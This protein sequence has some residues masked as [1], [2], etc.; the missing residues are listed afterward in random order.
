MVR[1]VEATDSSDQ[2]VREHAALRRVAT[3][4]AGQ[5][6]P[7]ELFAA[8]TE[9]AGRVLGAQTTNLMRVANPRLAVIVA[10]WSEGAAHVAVGSTGVLDGRGLVGKIVSTGRPSRVDDFDEVGGAVAASM[11]R[12]GLR[13][14][15][16]GPVVVDGRIWGAL[17]AC[18]A[19]AEPL[20]AGTED[21]VAA[22]AQLVALAIENAETREELAASRARLVAAADEA[23]RRIERD[24][25]DGAQQRLVATALSLSLLQRQLDKTSSGPS[26]LLVSA[27]E[28][29]DRG[30]CELREL[31]RGLHPA[32]LTDRGLEPAVRSLVG[33]VSV[34]TELRVAVPARLDP[35]IE[36]A[37]YFFV[38][39]ALTNVGKYANANSVSVELEVTGEALVATVTDDGIGG[40]DLAK[41]SGLRGLADRV[42]A[43][44]GRLEIDS[45]RGKGTK[46]RAELPT[47][48]P[49]SARA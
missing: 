45:V 46:L 4:V 16:A 13:S 33:R 49:G 36:A 37:A 15:V 35:T 5:P 42:Q 43:L 2:I 39:E 18:S 22:F 10:G 3:L 32:E 12:L 38:S 30:L 25:H 19:D 44:G 28:E 48:L 40:A 41:G 6:S 14:G 31:A 11:R 47:K 23:R 17:V 34:P 9:E 21:R 20:P 1:A 7:A 27:R 8:V 26:D 29:L 24:L